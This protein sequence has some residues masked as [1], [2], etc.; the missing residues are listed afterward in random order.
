MKTTRHVVQAGMLISTLTGV[1]ALGA[2]AEG[3]CPFGGVE[4]IFNYLHEGNLLCSLG[5]SNFYALAALVVSVLIIRR[6]FC[7]YLCPIG[8]ISEWLGAAAKRIGMRCWPVPPALDRALSLAKYAV[9]AAIVA[10]TW[11]AGELLFRGYCPCYALLSRHGTDIQVWTYVVAGGVGVASLGL[12]MPF[13]RWF[14]PLAAV[15]NPLSWVGLARVKRDPDICGNCGRCAMA[16]PMAIP[17]DRTRQVAAARCIACL[18]C[19]EACP[20]TKPAA[21]RW[22]P[23][24]WLGRAWP[25]AALIGILLLCGGAAVA[26]AYFAPLPSFVGS[27]GAP[28]RRAASVQ[29]TVGELTCRGR[30]FM[31]VAFLRRDDMYQIPGPDPDTPGYFKLEAWPDP[32]RA[33]VRIWYDPACADEEAIKRAISEPYFDLVENR[34][35]ISPFTIEGYL[36]PELNAAFPDPP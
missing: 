18:N 29:L 16:C 28:P 25:R 36:P 35:W 19:I 2:H 3:W 32:R 30:A 4:T 24:D 26:A 10:T 17:V 20:R 27:R 11:Y 6:A 1:F 21:L 22:G 8:A 14:C 34:W 5:V 13:C 12:A 7:G 23:P 33:V 15:L 31:L 9:L